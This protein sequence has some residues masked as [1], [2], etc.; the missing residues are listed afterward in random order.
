MSS[1]DID[2]LRR[3]L[4]P[5]NKVIIA[6]QRVGLALG[7]M[8]VLSV[9][10]RKSGELRTTPVSPLTVA[11]TTYVVG[12]FEKADW[13]KNARAAG[14]GELTRGRRRQRVALTELPVEERAPILR[15]F[16]TEVPHGVQFFVK[17]GVV[18]SPDPEAFAAAA[19]RCPVFRIDPLPEQ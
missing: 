16:P 7:T 13:V 18:T 3:R 6:L 12:G 4:K 5:V 19:P 14:W 11:G 2:R 8:H 9:P 1:T 17:T 15:A 10:G